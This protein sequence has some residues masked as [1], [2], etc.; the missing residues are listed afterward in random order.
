MT[1]MSGFP[2]DCIKGKQDEFLYPVGF[3]WPM[4]RLLKDYITET[5]RIAVVAILAITL[6][7]G[8]LWAPDIHERSSE[9]QPPQLDFSLMEPDPDMTVI[10]TGPT[11]FSV[12]SAVSDPD[13]PVASL[14]F[15]WFLDYRQTHA[16]AIS[17]GVSSIQ[18][19]PCL[20]PQL[21][22]TSQEHV[23]EVVVVDPYGKVEYDVSQNRKIVHAVVG[24]WVIQSHAVCQ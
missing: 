14:D 24:L 11:V 20:Y 15:L 10:M 12:T 7:G 1:K 13:D 6:Q 18:L 3:W 9:N 5:A 8:C 23:L 2:G 16:P 21:A 17:V 4:A 22:D 19:D